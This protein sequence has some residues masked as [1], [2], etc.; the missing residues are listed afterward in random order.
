VSGIP[1]Q[2]P[3][4]RSG[5]DD[6]FFERVFDHEELGRFDAEG[7]AASGLHGSSVSYL[8][9]SLY[10]RRPTQ[11]LVVAPGLEEAEA[12]SDDLETWGV[13]PVHYIP[14]LEVLPFDR[15]SPTREILATVQAGLHQLLC[16]QPGFY[17]T[18]LYGLRHKLMSPET[19]QRHRI[20]LRRGDHVD[21]EALQERLASMGYRPGGVV[22][23]PG[24][25]ALRGGLI[26]VY[27]P[28]HELPVRLEFF[29]DELDS[30]RAFE[31]MDQRS[32]QDLEEAV[33]I[34]AGPLVM[35][36]DTLL[37]ALARVES[38]EEFSQDDRTHLLERL[39]DRL[40]FSGLEGL[41]PFFHRQRTPAEY[42]GPDAVVAWVSPDDL[43]RRSE[44]LDAETT[45]V[46]GERLKRGDPVPRVEELIAPLAELQTQMEGRAQLWLGELVLAGSAP[47][48]LGPPAGRKPLGFA[49][50]AQERGKGE[51]PALLEAAATQ[52]AEGSEVLLFCDNRGQ[53]DRLAELF[54][55]ND[56]QGQHPRPRLQLGRLRGGFAWK[57]MGLACFTDHELFDRYQRAARRPRFRGAGRVR[58]PKA[59]RPGDFVVHTEHGIGRFLGL[60]RITAD[61][62]E[63]ECLLLEYADKDRL[64]IPTDKLLLVER[65]EVGD[66]GEPSLH[67]LGGGSWERT[68]TKA[69]K[70][71]RAM[72][73][74]LLSLYAARAALPGHASPPDSHLQREMEASFIH[75]ETPD[76]L[77]AVFAV[78]KDMESPRPMDRLV[79]GDVGFGK[80][81]V[82]MRA[83]FKAV[84]DGRQ[85][86]V[87][88]PT[89]ILAEQHGETFSQRLRDYPATVEVLSRF[90]SPKEQRDVLKRLQEGK[91]DILVGTHRLLGR[92]VKFPRLGLLVVDEEQR[93]GVR[94]KERLK[95]MRK[96]VDVL[97]LSAT[98]IPRT[99]YLSLMGAR[100][101]SIIATPPRDRL[102]IHTEVIPF[103]EEVIEEAILREMHRGGQVFF[104][105]N[106]V[107]TID[108]MAGIV[109]RI[110][111]SARIAVAHGQMKD[112]DLE[113]IMRDFLDRKYDVLVTTMI[114]ESGLDM[115]NVNTILIDRA[116][117]FG[118]SQ[119]H[120]LRGRVGRS[121]H[122]AYAHLMT[123]SGHTLAP[124]ARKRLAAIQ[125]FTDLGSGYHV[126]MRDLEI[127]GAGN[128]L[129]DAQH[130]H[131]AA[132]GFDLYC[133]LLE[134]EIRD[135]KGEGLP[136]LH[137]IKVDLRVP[138]YLP[139]EYL[140]EPEE[141]IR[142]YRELG[143]VADES[144][145]DQL[146]DELR[147]RFGP[148]P[149]EAQN[150]LDVTRIKLRALDCGVED[151]RWI[152]RGVR[153]IFAGDA[154]PNSAILKNLVGT[155]M[156]KLAFN[157]VDRLEMTVEAQREELMAASLVVLGR[158]A[159]ATRLV[160]RAGS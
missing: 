124:D 157:A 109:G 91:V 3:A 152:R 37:E 12:L 68:R 78:K 53:A 17:V 142:W 9:A 88:C 116:D 72:A 20:V 34:P 8:M 127:R 23:M 125:E 55:E 84:L 19:L 87:L 130:G 96:Q 151:V 126:A 138:A 120:Q 64:Y 108:T 135:L 94:H 101:M 11:W 149:P 25:L 153:L 136:R 117:R 75:E 131:I 79:C 29:G 112:A 100:D 82:A 1:T 70:A 5:F 36:D 62:V 52:V 114:I 57:A 106:R 59:L 39:Q 156:P 137:D 48:P 111:P 103:A 95:E 41:A 102:P 10:T 14:E 76:Q 46:R 143:R 145:L 129:G 113:L 115:P 146:R 22:E 158:L 110:V 18:T 66:D 141:K 33:L 90:K 56:P 73:Q 92:D 43:A 81:E 80:T 45:R 7:L 128:I 69:R 49:T 98:P 121:R 133:K 83:A 97:T 6:R 104:V 74:E 134:E 30:I 28:A 54:E 50:R 77:S 93:F 40:H 118:L 2:S 38:M 47:L 85:V 27:S 154:Q 31:P 159:E 63:S 60:R 58:D 51:I 35:D 24:D 147:D 89:T 44:E 122:R 61:G 67:K 150:L 123:P 139:D 21:T 26:D 148:P 15:K 132:I 65:Y 144:A 107:E 32:T 160:G 140:P 86:A 119:L 105:H 71:I 13:A 4:G 42:L 16:R 99:L 155:G